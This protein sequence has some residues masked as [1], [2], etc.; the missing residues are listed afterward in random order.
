M[1]VD[2]PRK[3]VT[4]KVCKLVTKLLIEKHPGLILE[5]NC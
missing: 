2:V 5:A 3:K 1:V 4:Y